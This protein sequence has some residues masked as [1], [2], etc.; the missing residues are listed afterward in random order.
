MLPLTMECVRGKSSSSAVLKF[1]SVRY[2]LLTRWEILPLTTVCVRGKSTSS[3]LLELLSTRCILECVGECYLVSLQ[4]GDRSSSSAVLSS[5][6]KAIVNA[7]G[8]SLAGHDM[9]P[10]EK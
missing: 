2:K 6:V 10:R 1:R 5:A 3:T 9:C 7:F 8:N 4:V